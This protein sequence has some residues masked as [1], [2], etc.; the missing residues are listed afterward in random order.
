MAYLRDFKNKELKGRAKSIEN[1]L[2]K[3]RSPINYLRCII[4]LHALSQ[5]SK[6]ENDKELL[7]NRARE[8]REHIHSPLARAYRDDGLHFYHVRQLNMIRKALGVDTND[9]IRLANNALVKCQKGNPPRYPAMHLYEPSEE[10]IADL[11][12]PDGQ[13]P[14]LA[15]HVPDSVKRTMAY[16]YYIIEP[17][18]FS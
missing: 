18:T 15:L 13:V 16:H 10:E 2:L 5:E 7:L 14:F 4:R 17:M 3:N 12:L 9:L 11:K 8:I 6:T 1:S